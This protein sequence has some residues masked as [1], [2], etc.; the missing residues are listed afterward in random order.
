MQTDQN[1]PK[2]SEHV[3]I[4]RAISSLQNQ[5]RQ[6]V[7]SSSS[8]VHPL[9]P[10]IAALA[11]SSD[12]PG[13]ESLPAIA[14]ALSRFEA[15]VLNSSNDG[16][17]SSNEK[18]RLLSLL[19]EQSTLEAQAKH[20]DEATTLSAKILGKRRR[21]DSSTGNGRTGGYPIAVKKG[22]GAQEVLGS[23]CAELG[24]EVFSTQ[25]EDGNDGQ[26]R[27]GEDSYMG[28][29]SGTAALSGKPT[30]TTLTIAGK[31]I[32]LDV[33]ITS[34]PSD[35]SSTADNAT[36]VASVRFS[37]GLGSEQHASTVT[38][39][40][41]DR[42][43]TRHASN[44]DWESLRTSLRVL[45]SLDE[46]LSTAQGNISSTGSS[47]AE[48][49]D[50][51]E[52]MQRLGTRVERVFKQ[53]L[54]IASS[55]A[56]LLTTG[57]GIAIMNQSTPYLT[58]I[59]HAPPAL[60]YTDEWEE[61]LA[62]GFQPEQAE[63]LLHAEGVRS[64]HFSV[65]PRS[66]DD[67]AMNGPV[68]KED[69]AGYLSRDT[70]GMEDELYDKLGQGLSMVAILDKPVS[71]TAATG[72]ALERILHGKDSP[73]TE[74]RH[75]GQNSTAPSVLLP[76]IIPRVAYEGPPSD[77]DDSSD[78][79]MRY[80]L[81]SSIQV[82][83]TLERFIF[84]TAAQLLAVLAVLRQQ[85]T[86]NDLLEECFRD[87]RPVD[88]QSDAKRETEITLDD[89]FSGESRYMFA[90]SWTP[91][92]V[93]SLLC[94]RRCRGVYNDAYYHSQRLHLAAVACSL[95]RPASLPSLAAHP[96][97]PPHH[98]IPQPFLRSLAHL[99][100]RRP[101]QLSTRLKGAA[102]RPAYSRW[103][104]GEDAESVGGDGRAESGGTVDRQ[105]NSEGGRE[106]LVGREE[107]GVVGE[108]TT[109]W[110]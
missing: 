69:L 83:H 5:L 90:I 59:L 28:S 78:S 24:W 39:P 81:S 66:A 48:R 53:E 17:S 72:R 84:D 79:S 74:A 1:P 100:H 85:L 19:K 33:D 10:P 51:F 42:L 86:W 13:N 25:N 99:Q 88:Q 11:S 65:M 91:C 27:N 60:F 4:S 23:I 22:A 107:A 73:A 97:Q 55:P 101:P 47:P 32:V 46:V 15:S 41:I 44:A 110:A 21:G 58:H 26:D 7:A 95:S 20:R 71:I 92:S 82:H 96:P 80:I 109:G 54:E 108:S 52:A 76:E 77:G 35:A 45:C 106:S 105:K 18:L 2:P 36:S 34:G 16:S 30:T 89:L 37:Y 14:A 68:G 3:T 75:I 56:H 40:A 102:G 67:S 38:D 31:S 70:S 9:H 87:S 61:T 63:K 57:H 64:V 6:A 50:P 29:G 94:R 49:V 62:S 104:R 93:C 43:L 103:R 12:A 98:A 8:L